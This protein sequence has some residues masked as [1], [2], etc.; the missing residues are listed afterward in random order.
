MNETP[1]L[2]SVVTQ[3]LPEGSSRQV[4]RGELFRRVFTNVS[5]KANGPRALRRAL[6]RDIAKE[7]YRRGERLTA[8]PPE[9]LMKNDS[10]LV[11]P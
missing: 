1:L 11:L 8:P 6:A 2:E 4:V 9:S 3:Y 10:L 7:M 5:T